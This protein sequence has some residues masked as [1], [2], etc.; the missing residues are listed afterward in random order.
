S[1]LAGQPG[2]F[3]A[4]RG[5]A[6]QAVERFR[7]R[8]ATPA[9]LLDQLDRAA[10][11]SFRPPDGD[12]WRR[13]AEGLGQ[14]GITAGELAALAQPATGQGDAELRDCL[15]A[16]VEIAARRLPPPAA[17]TLLTDWSRLDVVRADPPL[18]Q[19]LGHHLLRL[20]LAASAL[21]PLAADSAEEA[22]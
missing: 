18:R 6:W 8:Q 20:R 14:T 21:N 1:V 13:L 2:L 16:G 7:A 17:L 12:H 5:R 22:L 10:S 11:A 3:L 4:V 9:E 19:A 15:R